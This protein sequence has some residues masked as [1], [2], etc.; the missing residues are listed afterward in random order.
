MSQ[1]VV[2]RLDD[3]RLGLLA[4]D[5]ERVLRSVWVERLPAVSALVL[6]VI[7]VAGRVVPVVDLRQAFDLTE[8]PIRISD[9]F[10]IADTGRRTVALRIDA[11]E[12]VVEYEAHDCVVADSIIPRLKHVAGIVR[13]GDGLVLIQSLGKLLSLDQERALEDA[14]NAR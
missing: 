6:G 9:C 12:G 5:V 7:D 4:D 10:V 13:L 3:M 1:I 11:I 14:M 2:F 8:R